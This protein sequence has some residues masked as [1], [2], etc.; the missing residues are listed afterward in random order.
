MVLPHK[1][2]RELSAL[3]DRVQL[4][5][6]QPAEGPADHAKIGIILELWDSSCSL[7]G[8]L[9]LLVVTVA[10]VFLVDPGTRHSCTNTLGP[11]ITSSPDTD[12]GWF[13]F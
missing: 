5:K 9:V 2:V 13:H 3:E 10:L 6:L 12:H 1:Y 4:S 11:A 8:R 7:E